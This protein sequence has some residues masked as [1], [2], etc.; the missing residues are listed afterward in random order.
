MAVTGG[1]TTEEIYTYFDDVIIIT[2]SNSTVYLESRPVVETATIAGSFIFQDR[3]NS[4]DVEKVVRSK[5]L[6]LERRLIYIVDDL[7]KVGAIEQIT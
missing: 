6:D 5:V 2:G 4:K 7:G 3:E 1:D